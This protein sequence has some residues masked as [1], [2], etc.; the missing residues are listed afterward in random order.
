MM[1]IISTVSFK[2]RDLMYQGTLPCHALTCTIYNGIKTTNFSLLQ[3]NMVILINC[4][5]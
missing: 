2:G 1:I 3:I 4:T 5:V